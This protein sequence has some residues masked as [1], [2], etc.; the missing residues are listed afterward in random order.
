MPNWTKQRPL[1]DTAAQKLATPR[2]FIRGWQSLVSLGLLLLA[3][4]WLGLFATGTEPYVA[5]VA[6]LSL[7]AALLWCAVW[8]FGGMQVWAPT[9]LL[10]LLFCYCLL[11]GL[12]ALL[13]S[14]YSHAEQ[15]FILIACFL[16][17]SWLGSFNRYKIG[18]ELLWLV[19]LSVLLL[20]NLGM[21][22]LQ[23]LNPTYMPLRYVDVINSRSW[24]F[25][26]H[27]NYFAHFCGIVA[28]VGYAFATNSARTL[29]IF[30][31]CLAL[32][33][34]ISLL[35]AKSRG[36]LVSLVS[37]LVL[38]QFLNLYLL[39]ARES[40]WYRPALYATLAVLGLGWLGYEVFLGNVY[41]SRGVGSLA[42][43]FQSG[44]RT[45]MLQIAMQVGFESPWSGAGARGY[46]AA[47]YKHRLQDDQFGGHELDFA[48]NEYG[49]LF[50]D[51]GVWGVLLVLLGAA[52][53]GWMLWR[54]LNLMLM[55]GPPNEKMQRNSAYLVAAAGM[56]GFSMAH[57]WLDFGWH[58]PA[59]LCW[60]ALACG[61]I[62][63]PVEF[64]PHSLGGIAQRSVMIIACATLGLG[65][66]W[67][68]WMDAQQHFCSLQIKYAAERGEAGKA[69]QLA[70]QA[71][72]DYAD[73]GSSRKYLD[74]LLKQ[75]DWNDRSYKHELQE[76]AN[77]LLYLNP[78]CF[79]ARANILIA[80]LNF[81][82][83]QAALQRVESWL[84]QDNHNLPYYR[85]ELQAYAARAHYREA[86]TV[87]LQ[88]NAEGLRH[89]SKQLQVLLQKR[90]VAALLQQKAPQEYA[91][92][93]DWLKNHSQQLLP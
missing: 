57:A 48:H 58:I 24:G 2:C 9:R 16:G 32:V 39:K 63:A 76:V 13:G 78:N 68:G 8:W 1:L 33:A 19:F 28:M 3:L 72:L 51:Y 26:G 55:F 74:L 21:C 67:F 91:D 4:L 31:L 92:M 25:F 15:D 18:H 83:N 81:K 77:H 7:G 54:K 34:V 29:R 84:S 65:L 80:D 86:G 50:A 89:H 40:R 27:Y 30:W 10:W 71:W 12:R 37:G 60:A 46:G 62:L 52:V 14:E 22:A 85:A 6:Q 20:G 56:L 49:Q 75:P 5:S 90:E 38:I 41:A 44:G 35:A 69:R 79:Y 42:D 11:L 82:D 23:Q 87:S 43:F 88:Q 64:F 66:G 61:W 70:K 47:S 93:L 73:E 53:M 17:I 59:L 36:A 45:K